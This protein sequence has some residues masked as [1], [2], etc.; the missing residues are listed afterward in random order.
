[1]GDSGLSVVR[2][3]ASRVTKPVGRVGWCAGHQTL[4]RPKPLPNIARG[5]ICTTTKS[6]LK[7]WTKSTF[8]FI[9]HLICKNNSMFCINCYDSTSF[10]SMTCAKL[11]LKLILANCCNFSCCSYLCVSQNISWI[12]LNNFLWLNIVDHLLFQIIPSYFHYLLAKNFCLVKCILES[13]EY[14]NIEINCHK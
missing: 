10:V 3:V 12:P 13:F 9:K 2:L 11:F 8:T 14:G 5:N 7:Y 4:S 6:R 1:M